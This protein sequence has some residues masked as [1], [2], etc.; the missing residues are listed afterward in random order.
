MEH[1]APL[2]QTLLWVALIGG[3]VLRFHKPLFDLLVTLQKRIESGSTVRAGPFEISDQLKPQDPV[4]QAEKAQ[5]EVYEVLQLESGA[6]STPVAAEVASVQTAHF[7]A[8]DLA[9][10]ALQAEYGVAISRQV[11]AGADQGFDAAFVRKGRFHVVEVKYFR[12]QARLPVVRQAIDNLSH[13][14]TR[15]GWRNV[16]IVLAVVFENHPDISRAKARIQEIAAQSE[17]PVE[18]WCYSLDELRRRF[19]VTT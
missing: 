1:I 10:R 14:I 4:A 2:L 9:L 11:T 6:E 13:A 3:I 17:V 5:E 7:Q 18:V 15:Y 16:H 19:G 8:E 12:N